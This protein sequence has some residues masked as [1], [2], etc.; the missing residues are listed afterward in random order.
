MWLARTPSHLSQAL[1]TAVD[2]RPMQW[3]PGAVSSGVKRQGRE[4]DSMY[5]RG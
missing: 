5:C 4:A 1:N 2:K 3:V